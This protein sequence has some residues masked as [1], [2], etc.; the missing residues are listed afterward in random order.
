M[1]DDI[2]SGV[3]GERGQ[4]VTGRRQDNPLLKRGAVVLAVIA[5]VGFALWSMRDR[6][7]RTDAEKPERVVIRQTSAFEPAR[8]PAAM[9]EVKLPT[10]VVTPQAAPADDP[11]LDAARRAPVMA[12]G[13]QRGP[14]NRQQ[15]SGVPADAS[16]NYVPLNG[17]GG[18][19]NGP[20]EN[21]D[22]RFGRMMT[23]T[24]LEG[25]RAGTLG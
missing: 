19:F 24:R 8:Q 7:P 6:G 2:E 13:A 5:F 18:G 10:P 15:A 25:S 4:S 21:E 14:Q 16:S 3:P 17:A 9:P 22:Q 11:L 12:F 1:A 23:P 20:G